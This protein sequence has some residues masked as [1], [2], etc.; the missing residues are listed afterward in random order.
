MT[1]LQGSKYRKACKRSRLLPKCNNSTEALELLRALQSSNLLSTFDPQIRTNER[2]YWRNFYEKEEEPRSW[3]PINEGQQFVCVDPIKGGSTRWVYILPY[4]AVLLA[5]YSLRRR[6][7]RLPWEIYLLHRGMYCEFRLF[8]SFSAITD[9]IIWLF[10][11]PFII[12][13]V[14]TIV[15]V[16]TH[17][18]GSRGLW[19]FPN[20]WS[21]STFFGPF[22]PLYSWDTKPNESM[23]LRWRRFGNTM[24]AEMGMLRRRH[25]GRTRRISPRKVRALQRLE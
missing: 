2:W 19:L 12:I 24:L 10:I 14:R 4:L 13:F 21:D 15:F 17:V 8:L 9:A 20:L 25:G 23:A 18:W 5:L 22:C 6:L 3:S 1:I 11:S 16:I 7:I